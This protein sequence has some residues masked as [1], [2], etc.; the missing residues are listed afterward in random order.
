MI[1]LSRYVFETLREDGEFALYRGRR[2]EE[3][4][5]VLVVAPLSEYPA[6]KS[7]KRL[8]HEYSLRDELEQLV[9][10]PE[11][12]HLLLIGAYRDNEVTADHP[13]ML[14]LD[15]IRRTQATVHEI[16]LQPLSLEDVKQLL[17]D[18]LLE[19]STA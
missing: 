5:A 14:A 3:L 2:D 15:A 8:E 17:G 18:T 12:R 16:V 9:T 6:L 13:L 10:R 1:E 11:V 7:I 19:V 4:S